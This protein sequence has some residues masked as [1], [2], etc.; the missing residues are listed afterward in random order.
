MDLV[1]EALGRGVDG[2]TNRIDADDVR[3]SRA[4]RP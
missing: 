1:G 4:A 2:S 3:D